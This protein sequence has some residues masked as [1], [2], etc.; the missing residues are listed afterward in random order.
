[1]AK[2]KRSRSER[3]RAA[4]DQQ[5]QTSVVASE[6]PADQSSA[7]LIGT[8]STPPGQSSAGQASRRSKPAPRSKSRSKSRPSSRS[9]SRRGLPLAAIGWSIGGVAVLA[10]L[11]FAVTTQGGARSADAATEQL[12][13]TNAGTD[14]IVYSGRA[15]VVYHSEPPLPSTALPRA[16]GQPTLVWF[17]AV[18]CPVCERMAPFVHETASQY[19]DRLVFIEKSIDEDRD[20]SNRYGVRGTPTFIMLDAAGREV[21]RFHGQADAASFAFAIEQALT[22]VGG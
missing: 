7:E 19:T 4:R 18:W 20:S 3:R 2:R 22:A 13:R 8:D 14:V 5:P 21:S 15:H 6:L 1:M 12:A 11:V 10:L 9:T 17:S 16:D